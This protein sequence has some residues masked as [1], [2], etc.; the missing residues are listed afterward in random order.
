[1]GAIVAAQEAI[2]AAGGDIAYD[3]FYDEPTD[4]PYEIYDGQ[5]PS[6]E[7]PMLD[8]QG[9]LKPFTEISPMTQT[10]NRQL[11]FQRLH[12]SARVPA[13]GGGGSAE[14]QVGRPWASRRLCH[15]WP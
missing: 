8:A 2:A 13:G 4:T 1:M 15:S 9:Q 11:M 14:D 6:S 5:N 7:I 10:L 3:L 12:V